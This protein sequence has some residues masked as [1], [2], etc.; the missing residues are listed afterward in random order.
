MGE[1]QSPVTITGTVQTIFNVVNGSRHR[2]MPKKLR[3]SD[4]EG[5]NNANSNF[6]LTVPLLKEEYNENKSKN[7]ST[8]AT[9]KGSENLKFMVII[10]ISFILIGC[11]LVVLLCSKKKN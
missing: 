10:A 11:M 2:Y 5:Y 1:K 9:L 4:D 3:L 6:E 7:K 8:L